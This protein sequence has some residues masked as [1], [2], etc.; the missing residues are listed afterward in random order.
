MNNKTFYISTILI[1]SLLI[2][3]SSCSKDSNTSTPLGDSKFLGVYSNSLETLSITAQGE[4]FIFGNCNYQGF[5]EPINEDDGDYDLRV[6]FVSGP[7]CLIQPETYNCFIELSEP[8]L[9]IACGSNSNIEF[10]FKRGN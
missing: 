5:I 7:K 3:C 2:L 9:L 1:V 6:Y 4:F 8:D 10:N